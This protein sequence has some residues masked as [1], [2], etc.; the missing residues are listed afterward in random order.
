MNVNAKKKDGIESKAEFLVTLTWPDG[1]DDDI[2]LWVEDPEGNMVSF[3]RREDGLMHLERDDLGQSNDLVMTDEGPVQVTENKEIVTIRGIVPG[4]YVVNAH[5]YLKRSADPI[6]VTVKVEK[7]NPY[8]TISIKTFEMY[9]SGNEVT[10]SRFTVEK[11]GKVKSMS[12][13]SKSLISKGQQRQ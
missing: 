2:D 4:E 8:Y 5:A 1:L 9:G 12:D 3:H 11:S 7:L 10:A 13:L 6:Q